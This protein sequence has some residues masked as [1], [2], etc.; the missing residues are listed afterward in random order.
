MGRAFGGGSLGGG[1]YGSF[2]RLR[3]GRQL[4]LQ[5]SAGLTGA[6]GFAAKVDHS[7][8]RGC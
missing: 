8:C 7:P 6:G 4:V 3:S 5:S 1:G 2:L